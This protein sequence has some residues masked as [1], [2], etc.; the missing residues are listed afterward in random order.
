[1][2]EMKSDYL[3]CDILHFIFNVFLVIFHICLSSFNYNIVLYYMNISIIYVTVPLLITFCLV[4]QINF[5]YY[6]IVNIFTY[7]LDMYPI[8]VG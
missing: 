1:M 3:L 7:S 5:Y 8:S 4:S 6:N 2:Y